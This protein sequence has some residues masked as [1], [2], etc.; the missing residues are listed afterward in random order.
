MFIIVRQFTDLIQTLSLVFDIIID[1]NIK[2]R[3]VNYYRAMHNHAITIKMCLYR[4]MI[5]TIYY[6]SELYVTEIPYAALTLVRTINN[7]LF[8]KRQNNTTLIFFQFLLHF[9]LSLK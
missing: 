4:Y 7:I 9:A 1:V 5:S 6:Y 3:I 2:I 8:S